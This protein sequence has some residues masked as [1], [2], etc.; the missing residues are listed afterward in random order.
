MKNKLVINIDKFRY[1]DSAQDLLSNL[2]IN[3]YDGDILWLSG[4]VGCG[5]TTLLKVIAGIIPAFESGYLDGEVVFNGERVKGEV[6]ENVAFCFQHSD[7]QLLFD[8]VY[9]QFFG[10]Q[11]EI[12]K[13][14]YL[15]EVGWFNLQ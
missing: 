12:K 13:Y 8:T 9:R 2:Y 14:C 10:E 3:L 5:K 15:S 7:N 6:L 11:R 1:E 4:A